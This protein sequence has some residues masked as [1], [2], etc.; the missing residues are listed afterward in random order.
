M[1]EE[2]RSP[3]PWTMLGIAFILVFSMSVPMFCVPPMEHILKEELLL[4]HAQTSLL[5]TA[6]FIGIAA[7]AIPGGMLADRIGIR[8]AAGIGAI[9]IAVGALLRGTTTD[10][11]TIFTFTLLVGVGSALVF[12]NLPKLVSLWVPR[13]RFGA[14]TGIYAAA[15]SVSN[16]I[17]VSITLPLIFPITGTFQGTFLIWGIPAVIAAVVWWTLAKDPPSINIPQE[18][19]IREHMPFRAV[20][21]NKSLWLVA[22]LFF[23]HNIFF[24]SWIGWAPALMQEKGAAPEVAALIASVTMWIA[25]PTVIFVPRLSDRLGL[26]KPFLWV[27]STILV[28]ASLWAVYV[29]VPMGWL[30]M[31]IVGLSSYSRFVTVMVL[32]AEIMPKQVGLASGFIL[33]IGFI[34]GVI[35]PW[36]GGYTLDVTGSLNLSMLILMGVSAAMAVI[37]IR[38]PET[39]PRAR[40]G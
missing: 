34:G 33:S 24:T 17:A 15:T 30:L 12:P 20:L 23:L 39:G 4:S 40:L 32:Q 31:A 27:S 26:R 21:K 28:F 5:F 13:D 8:K 35:G 1:Q 6:P 19:V 29:S 22:I 14:A 37:A 2:K 9:I 18:Q 25:I 16:A 36:I 10:Y 38:I 11:L 7:L 3:M